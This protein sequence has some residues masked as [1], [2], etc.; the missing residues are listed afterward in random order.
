MGAPPSVR[1]LYAAGNE[2]VIAIQSLEVES[3]TL[4]Y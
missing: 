1:L 3:D 4:A 2:L